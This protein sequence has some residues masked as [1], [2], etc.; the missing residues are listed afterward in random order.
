MH[1]GG[2]QRQPA[3]FAREAP[4]VYCIACGRQLPVVH[5]G[6]RA[7]GLALHLAGRHGRYCRAEYAAQERRLTGGPRE[8]LLQTLHIRKRKGQARWTI[9]GLTTDGVLR[10]FGHD[11]S[12]AEGVNFIARCQAPLKVSDE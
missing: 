11:W 5:E 2:L 10:N 12:Q 7:A 6:G 3:R 1:P 4:P 8:L 9:R